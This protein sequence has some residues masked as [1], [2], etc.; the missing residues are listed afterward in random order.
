M[1]NELG[2][3]KLSHHLLSLGKQ[4]GCL[5]AGSNQEKAKVWKRGLRRAR[6]E[7]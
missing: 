7:K 6:E 2:T 1:A 3:L 5:A 4:L